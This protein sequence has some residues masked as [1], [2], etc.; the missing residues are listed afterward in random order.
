MWLLLHRQGRRQAQRKVSELTNEE[1]WRHLREMPEEMDEKEN[2]HLVILKKAAVAFVKSYT[3]LEE[4]E[5]DAQ[6]DITIAVLLLI[7]DMYDNRQL[8]VDKNTMNKTA[9]MILGMHSVNLL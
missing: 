3:G 5:L 4:E 8:Q 2:Q 7:G 6:E 1:I 9:E